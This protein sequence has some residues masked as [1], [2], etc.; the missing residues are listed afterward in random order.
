[1]GKIVAAVATSH[2]FAL[3]EPKQ[4]DIGRKRNLDSYKNKYGPTAPTYNGEFESLEDA[5]KRYSEIQRAHDQF[6]D[7]LIKRR[8]TAA[9]I[10]GDD[11][12]ENLSEDNLPQLAVFVG[13]RFMVGQREFKSNREIN[14]SLLTGLVKEGFE[15]AHLG[16][17]EDGVLLSHAHGP[18]LSRL[19]ADI[20]IPVTVVF[21]NAIH[22]PAM[23]PWRCYQLG[24]AIQKIL[25]RVSEDNFAIIGSGGLSHFTAGYPWKQYSGPFTYG[26]ISTE[27]DHRFLEALK[28][29]RVREFTRSIDREDLLYHGEL[30]TRSWL[31]IAG[32]VGKRRPELVAYEPFYRGLMGMGVAIW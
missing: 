9:L 16:K 14:L 31:A 2:A 26:S 30:E 25:D 23:E 20:D 10:I 24:K 1:M 13:D 32:M 12:D 17:L 15:P 22:I 6:R 27:F 5:E 8:V 29:H 18:V 7:L 28:Q 19:L 3:V 21:L 4:W 11:Q